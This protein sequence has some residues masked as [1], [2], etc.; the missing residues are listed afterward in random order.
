MH[1]DNAYT[2]FVAQAKRRN[3][4]V[5]MITE[6]LAITRERQ[7]ELFFDHVAPLMN[8][9]ERFICQQMRAFS[10]IGLYQNNSA[11]LNTLIEHPKI[12]QEIPAAEQL[13]QHLRV[14]V[15]KYQAV[16]SKHPD[17]CLVYVG[18]EDGVPYP[19]EVDTQIR[20]W[21]LAAD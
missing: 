13:A 3:Q 4:L 5:S 1:Q 7:Y 18:V 12:M 14:W 6:R 8:K 15:N 2:A 21:L 10:D 16:F 11:V 17:M 9:E 19:S 20:E